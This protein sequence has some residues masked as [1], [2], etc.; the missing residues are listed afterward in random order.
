MLMDSTPKMKS[1][2]GKI[3]LDCS[4]S[5]NNKFDTIKNNQRVI[6]NYKEKDECFF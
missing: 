4:N 3:S 5:K 6:M 2:E 1:N